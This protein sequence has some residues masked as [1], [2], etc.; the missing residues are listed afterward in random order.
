MAKYLVQHRRGTI[1][2]W[3]NQSTLIPLEGELVIEIDEIHGLHKLK[4][5]DGIHTYAE[6]AYL[7][8]GDEV[9]SQVIAEVKPRVVT[10]TLYKDK[11]ELDDDGLLYQTIKPDGITPYSRLDLQPSIEQ[12]AKFKELGIVFV[13]KNI[14]ATDDIEVYLIGNPSS[15]LEDYTMQATIIETDTEKHDDEDSIIGSPVGASGATVQADW[16]Q[17][18]DTQPDYIKNKPSSFGDQSNK[19]YEGTIGIDGNSEDEIFALYDE[20]TSG[21]TFVIKTPIA[22]GKHSYTAYVYDKTWKAMDGNYNAENVYFD[23]DI[24]IT[25]QVGNIDI[26]DSGSGA[27]PSDGKNLRQVFES[28]WTKELD[29][30]AINPS[31]TIDTTVQYKEIGTTITPTYSASF[32]E[33]SYSYDKTTGVTVESWSVTFGDETKTESDSSFS[34]IVVTE[35]ECCNVTATATYSD[36]NIPKTNLGNDCTDK[37]IKAGITSASKNLIVGYKPN[38]YGFKTAAI[39]ISTINSDTIRGLTTNQK[40]TTTPVSSAKSDTSWMQFF[41]AVPKGRKT[42]LSAKDSNNLPLTVKSKDVVVN[43]IDGVSSTYTL[44][45]IDNDAAYGA[46][47]LTLIWK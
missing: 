24:I 40:Q 43:H 9:V 16:N 11:W 8:A 46:T 42:S 13:P 10:V 17:T 44:F 41:Y 31:V 47:T 19:H 15:E 1:A 45:Y 23:R 3:V 21:D 30:T 20:Y 6:L 2:Q 28:I 35:G 34:D 5:G 18:D 29:P 7:M 39:D 4:I 22:N 37:Q 12:L 27:I 36:G 33:G 26:S 14:K 38:F 25:T 32:D